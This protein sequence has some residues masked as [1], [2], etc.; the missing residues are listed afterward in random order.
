MNHYI[1]KK[2]QLLNSILNIES[3]DKKYINELITKYSKDEMKKKVV[4][5]KEDLF[6]IL[7][8]DSNP[9]YYIDSPMGSKK[10]FG[11]KKRVLP[12]DYGE[13]SNYINPADDMGWDIIIPPS[14]GE[15]S[16]IKPI[17]VVEVNDDPK[18]WK[19]KA[20]R[21]PPIG[22]DKIIVSNDGNISKEDKKIIEDFFSTMW[23][24][25]KI[26]WYE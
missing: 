7:L 1:I 12:F 15:L 25:K 9:K 14:N 24:F 19:E 10:G 11:D 6:K 4:K 17:G 22:N 20:D 3:G 13:L 26:K 5:N 18:I 23:Q 16:S 8:S 2:L 21:K